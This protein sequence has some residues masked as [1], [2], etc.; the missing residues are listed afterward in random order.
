MKLTHCPCGSQKS[1]AL[2]CGRYH[3]GNIHAPTAEALMRSRYSAYVLNNAQYIYRTW[4][5][6]TRPPLK[7]LREESSQLF[8]QL[9]IKTTTKGDLVDDDTGTVEFIASYT[10]KKS[11]E[12][13][14]HHENSYFIKRN[15]RWVYVNELSK[16]DLS[17]D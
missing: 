14:Q 8:N 15:N 1:Y 11:D 9:H 10:L 2:C 17:S 16:V 5:E 7:V 12:T 13:H 3:K 4:D 6:S